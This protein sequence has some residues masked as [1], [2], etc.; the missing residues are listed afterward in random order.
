MQTDRRQPAINQNGAK[1]MI[2]DD[3]PELRIALKTRLRANQ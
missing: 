2:V 3:D 1:I